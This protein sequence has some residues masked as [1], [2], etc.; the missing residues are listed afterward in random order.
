MADYVR[1]PETDWQDILDAVRGKT[2]EKEKMLSGVVAKAIATIETGGMPTGGQRNN[3]LRKFNNNDYSYYWGTIFPAAPKKGQI[4]V[5]KNDVTGEPTPDELSWQ[6][7][8]IV[9]SDVV[10]I[11]ATLASYQDSTFLIDYS[12]K[13]IRDLNQTGK[14]VVLVQNDNNDTN[15]YT[16]QYIFGN[17]YSNPFTAQGGGYGWSMPYMTEI[18][19]EMSTVVNRIEYVGME[20]DKYKWEIKKFKIPL[21][22]V[23]T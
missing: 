1:V 7:P 5:A 11:K 10:V 23:T 17:M 21:E 12:P 6:D 19:D 9:A 15:T 14:F 20:N 3:I 4:L 18:N 13:M 8:A 2:G 22:A 16:Y